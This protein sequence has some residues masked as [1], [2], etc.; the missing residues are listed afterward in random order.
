MRWVQFLILLCVVLVAQT[1][2]GGMITFNLGPLGRAA[3][4]LMA[5]MAVF[6][7][8][9]GPNVLSVMIAA[10]ALGFAVGVTAVG[11]V[12][13]PTVLGPMSFAYAM[14]AWLIFRMREAVFGDHVVTQGMLALLFC[15]VS[16]LVWV[17]AQTALSGAW[18][19]YRPLILQAIGVSVY[20]AL[21]MPVGFWLLSRA[22]GLFIEVP[23]RR[24]RRSRRPAR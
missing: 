2:L 3:P 11:G 6:V 8:L 17:T 13:P 12:G 4:D 18:V 24:T 15:A 7:A 22:Q 23:V 14:A 5:I 1:T 16:H 20:T 10:W 19:Y 9:R 21:L